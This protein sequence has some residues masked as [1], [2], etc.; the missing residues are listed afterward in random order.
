MLTKLAMGVAS[1]SEETPRHV[2]A[3]EE[4]VQK[5]TQD[6]PQHVAT[7]GASKAQAVLAT[8][9]AFNRPSSD[10]RKRQLSSME[11]NGLDIGLLDSPKLKLLAGDL[12]AP[13]FALSKEDFDALLKNVTSIVHNGMEVLSSY[14]IW[15]T[16]S[17]AWLV[18][19]NISLSSM[20]PLVAGTRK[21]IDFALTSP[22]PSPPSL[23]FVSTVGVFRNGSVTALEGHISD[24]RI[25]VG[26]GYTE[27]KWVAEMLLEI[28]V[29]KTVLSPIIVRV[30]QLSGAENGAWSAKEWFPALLR[31]SQLLGHLPTISGHAAKAV[32]EVRNSRERYMHLIHP[33]PVPMADILS[34]LS[35]ILG[36]P[37]VPY[38]QWLESLEAASLLEMEA[39]IN[40]AVHLL[41]FFRSYSAAESEQELLSNTVAL[42]SAPSLLSVALLPRKMLEMDG[43]FAPRRIPRLIPNISTMRSILDQMLTTCTYLTFCGAPE[44]GD[45]GKLQQLSRIDGR[46]LKRL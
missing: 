1:K 11:Q 10:L 25:S 32:V 36:L 22:L 45:W 46:N 27:S 35:K 18:N 40:P 14:D 16:Y 5:C 44:N 23:L 12:N 42:E 9:Y 15:L 38:S 2:D 6:F 4:M 33:H 26:L 20:E 34:P 7:A 43:S 3:M 31:S 41:D 19:F 29:K 8:V 37:L 30:G 28:A 21:L 13:Q 24:P 39:S 17:P